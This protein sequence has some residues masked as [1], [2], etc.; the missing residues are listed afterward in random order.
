MYLDVGDILYFIIIL[1]TQWQQYQVYLNGGDVK[2]LDSGAV[3]C[4]GR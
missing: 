3:Q 4:Y 2:Y 1:N